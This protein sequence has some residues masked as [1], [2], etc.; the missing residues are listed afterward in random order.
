[1]F[2]GHDVH[3]DFAARLFGADF[4]KLLQSSNSLDL[5]LKKIIVAITTN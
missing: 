2:A 5:N 1:V 4:R 3:H